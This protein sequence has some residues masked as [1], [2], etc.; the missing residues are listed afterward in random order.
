MLK[1]GDVTNA[2]RDSIILNAGVGLYVYGKAKS[3]EEGV[4][5]ARSTLY[6]GKATQALQTFITTSQRIKQS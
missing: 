2:K 5:M 4:E 1:E 6:A 3:I